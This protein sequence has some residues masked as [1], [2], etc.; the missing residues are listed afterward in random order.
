MTTHARH[1]QRQGNTCRA[2]GTARQKQAAKKS[3]YREPM[4]ILHTSD[5]HLGRALLGQK[6]HAE[7]EAFLDWLTATVCN[8]RVDVLL[9]T[10]D[11][12]DS[13]TPGNRDQQMYFTF[14]ARMTATCCRHVVVVA[15][16]HDSPSFLAAPGDL[17]RSLSIHVTG[18][19]G[20]P[21]D[22]VLVL[23]NTR[24]APELIVCAVPYLRDR[25]IRTVEAG[26]SVDDKERKLVQG[27]RAHYERVAALAVR[28]REELAAEAG[29][30]LPIVGTGHLFAAGGKTVEGDGVRE[31]YVGSLLHVS[32]SIFPKSFDYLALGHLHLPQTVGGHEHIRYSGSPLPMGF[33]EAG[34]QKS[35]CLVEVAHDTP[36]RVR[37]LPVPVFRHLERIRGDWE[38]IARRIGE[39]KE[40]GS[41]VWLEIVYTGHA[42]MGD[43]GRQVDA[44]VSGSNLRVCRTDNLNAR[45]AA[46]HSVHP[47]ETL[48]DLSV[49]DVFRRCLRAHNVPKEQHAELLRTY[50][51]ALA[52][53]DDPQPHSGDR[54]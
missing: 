16:N 34:Q 33:G 37:L 48:D 17:L 25:D 13:G 7:F 8:E 5:W 30:R 35:V 54:V 45:Q 51:E 49:T 27:I 12:F 29:G 23:R 21:E 1:R 28:R 9:V 3:G 11:I 15:G 53:L 46:L 10:G 24:N 50:G 43:L 39:L 40:A 41:P 31:L 52:A 44:A 22:E 14:L 42:V 4:K 20:S 2:R 6:R 18:S 32:A 38:H 19:A 26:E 47:G 36:V